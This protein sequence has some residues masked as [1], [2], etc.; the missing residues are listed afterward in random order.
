MYGIFPKNYWHLVKLFLQLIILK[1][2]ISFASKY[3]FALII[4]KTIISFAS[5]YNFALSFLKSVYCLTAC[6]ILDDITLRILLMVVM[7]GILFLNKFIDV[8]LIFYC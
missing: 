1:T 7:E 2:I 3:N 4:L 5:K 6:V 8:L